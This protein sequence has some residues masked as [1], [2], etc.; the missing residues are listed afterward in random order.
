MIHLQNT[1]GMY[2]ILEIFSHITG[3]EILYANYVC[4][5]Y[6][7]AATHFPYR[8]R[9]DNI[10]NKGSLPKINRICSSLLQNVILQ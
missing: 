2:N 8:L 4:G 7:T 1:L 10:I 6:N 9:Q 3:K 5:L